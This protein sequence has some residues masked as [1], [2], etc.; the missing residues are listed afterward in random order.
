MRVAWIV[1]LVAGCYTAPDY[2]GTHFKCDAEHACPDGQPCVDG[3]C[4]GS[5]GSDG[6]SDMIDA[7]PST[8]G[9]Q[10]GAT[11]CPTDQQCCA[12]IIGSVMCIALT[13]TC[14]GFAATCDGT[15]DCA[16][17]P[18][19]ETASHTIAC[20]TACSMQIC[21]EDDDCTNAS[22]SRC[23]AAIGTGEPWGRCYPVCP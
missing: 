8:I 7:S 2:G 6:G 23:C 11:I 22:A 17:G 10:C 1:L 20:G 15:E 5:A 13:A 21:L 12:S 3:V 4:A 18:C 9:V 14:A 16:G 19:C